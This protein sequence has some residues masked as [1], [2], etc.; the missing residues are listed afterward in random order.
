MLKKMAKENI[1]L[2]HLLILSLPVLAYS[3][4]DEQMCLGSVKSSHEP[5]HSWTAALDEHDDV[6]GI[7][8]VQVKGMKRER[9]QKINTLIGKDESNRHLRH[10]ANGMQKHMRLNTSDPLCGHSLSGVD[11]AA[12]LATLDDRRAKPGRA[13]GSNSKLTVLRQQKIFIAACLH[14]SEEIFPNW[15]SELVRLLMAL[16]NSENSANF[17]VSIYESGSL[18]GTVGYLLNLD[19]HLKF[20]GVPSKIVTGGIVR[21]ERQRIEFMADIRNKAMEPL[22]ASPEAYDHV[23][24]LNDVMFCA[25][26]VLQ[27][28]AHALPE[29]KG[30]FGADAVCGMDYFW[31]EFG[32]VSGKHGECLFY[33]RWISHDIAGNNFGNEKPFVRDTSDSPGPGNDKL[34]AGEPFQVFSCWN[35]M[36]AFDAKIFQKQGLQFRSKRD[37][38]CPASEAELI[39]RDMW[40]AGRGK[41]LVS[42]RATSAYHERHFELCARE[43]Q[44]LQFD[45]AP[46]IKKWAPKPETLR[47][48]PLLPN[49]DFVEYKNCFTEN[50]N[51]LQN[52]TSHSGTRS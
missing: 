34:E 26:G 51:T 2:S 9:T 6:N 7:E 12:L 44:P 21:D 45:S 32:E 31:D 27:L 11:D 46:P 16:M 14:Q 49:Q 3:A 15:T 41:V 47:C 35:G 19:R 42:P 24:W 37:Q 29:K 5:L 10:K 39:F 48:C 30:G 13:S 20:L 25:D 4:A 28:L 23:L 17:F 36:V 38:E 8:L 50:L 40:N 43:S 18:D 52:K 33:D 1:S 22:R